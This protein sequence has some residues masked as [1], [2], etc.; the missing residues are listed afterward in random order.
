[1][2][3]AIIALSAIGIFIAGT[4]FAVDHSQMHEMMMKKGGPKPDDRIELK[5]PETMKVMQ[6]GMMRQHLNTVSD[7]TAALAANDLTKAA[8]IAKDNLGWNQAEEQ[9]CNMVSEMTGEKDF[10]TYGMAVHKTADE[11]SASA[12]AGNRDKALEQLS[13]LIKNCNA[14]HEKFRH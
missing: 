11:L 6:K 14:C 8:A 12:A 4:S 3:R 2:K 5:L 10:L 1:M 13:K 9:R 7:I